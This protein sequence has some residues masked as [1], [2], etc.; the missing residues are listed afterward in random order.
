[1]NTQKA[2][3][4]IVDDNPTNLDLLAESLSQVGFKVLVAKDGQRAIRQAELAQPD[5]ILLDV[6]MPGIDGFETCRRLK[7]Y[8][9]TRDIPV[10]FMTALAETSNEVKGLQLGAVD[11]IT[12]PIQIERV[13]ARLETHLTLHNLQKEIQDK[14]NQLQQ[15]IIER[16]QTE[17]ALRQSEG[18]YRTLV[19]TMNEGLVILNPNGLISYV[20]DRYCQMFGYVCHDLIGHPVTKLLNEVNRNILK[21][22]LA[23]RIE[24]DNTPYELI[25]THKDGQKVYTIVSP[26]PIFNA[27]GHFG[28]SF[29]IITD[30]TALKRA[31][32]QL[33]HTALHDALT[34]LPNRTLF[35][36]R[37]KQ[38]IKQAKQCQDYLFA[39]LF[40]DLDR[41]KNINDSLGHLVG[42]QLLISIARRLEECIR[43]IDTVA[44]LGGDEFTILLD[45][46]GDISEAE[47]IAERIQSQLAL[48][49]NLLD[50]HQI[51]TTASI[52]IVSGTQKYNQPEDL[53]RDADTAMYQAKARGKARYELFDSDQHVQVVN[54]WQL[55]TDLWRAVEGQEFSVYYQ[56]IVS[57]LSGQIAGVEALLRWQHPQRGLLTPA[58]FIPL[59]EETGLIVPLG[60]WLLRMVCAQIKI[61][62]KAGYG[63]LWV[64]VNMSA[65]Q[66]QEQNVSALIQDILKE[67]GLT[68][69]VMILEIA[70]GLA[71]QNID[72]SIL[73]ELKAMGFK[74]SID[75]FGIGS[76][77]VSLKDFPLDILKIDQSF[78]KGMLT[79]ADD[80]T[81]VIAMIAMA[82]SLNLKVIAEGVETEAQ[83][84][85]LRANQCDEIQGYLFSPPVPAPEMTKLL[86]AGDKYR[87][88]PGDIDEQLDL[89]IRAQVAQDIGYA[90]VDED[91]TILVSNVEFSRWIEGEANDF[92]G[93][94][95]PEVLPELVGVENDLRQLVHKQ[96]ETFII[97]KIYRPTYNDGTSALEET[98]PNDFGHYF[99]LQ[100][101][102]FLGTGADLLVI[103]TNVTDQARLEFELRQKLN[104]LRLDFTKSKEAERVRPI[105]SEL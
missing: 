20:N 33:R 12:K 45:N 6:M 67:A 103:V 18:Q 55:E 85:F 32:E 15:K 27:A 2:T 74:L 7:A 69:Q 34:G 38:V 39:V 8:Q 82:H 98:W 1:M 42:D 56:P 9:A 80:K 93:Q 72:L 97:P 62:H 16:Q 65:R 100:I 57:L 78:V 28:G 99:D 40:I 96:G 95:L 49:I 89:S 51:F 5:L 71:S 68:P 19:E 41:F 26:Q 47:R 10:I 86:P 50:Q 46:I 87:L 60:E 77:L 83:L 30:I 91:L 37:L 14:N 43:P 94:L 101:E 44:R 61:W 54:R 70:E 73:A 4:L 11:Y 23:G 81:I 105:E 36:G 104:N 79:N 35:L 25:V 17:Q 92:V 22:Q 66:I 64:A 63:S 21:E 76:S 48:P 58:E 102:P 59:A 52:G 24:G 13:L 75:D 31:Q 90:L 3:I 53:L 84:A 29:A 88:K